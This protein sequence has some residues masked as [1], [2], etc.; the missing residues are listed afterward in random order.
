MIPLP[1]ENI[2]DFRLDARVGTVIPQVAPVASVVPL[3]H[4]SQAEDPHSV[5]VDAEI[6]FSH[7]CTD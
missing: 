5:F 4:A 7:G 1:V 2:R 6:N 3:P